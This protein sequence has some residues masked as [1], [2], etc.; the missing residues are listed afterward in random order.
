MNGFSLL[1]KTDGVIKTGD[2]IGVLFHSVFLI[3]PF[4]LILV[5]PNCLIIRLVE[6]IRFWPLQKGGTGNA[7]VSGS[8][9]L[10]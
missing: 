4:S 9:K 5:V 8:P 7:N 2:L 10:N 6:K 1:N 3:R